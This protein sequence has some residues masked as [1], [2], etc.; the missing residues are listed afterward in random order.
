MAK[1][2]AENEL[3]AVGWFTILT[4]FEVL[5]AQRIDS[6]AADSSNSTDEQEYFAWNVRA[7]NYG[8]KTEEHVCNCSCL[9][10]VCTDQSTS[11]IGIDRQCSA[12]SPVHSRF[13]PLGMI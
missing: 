8:A 1:E 12:V 3:L 11:A 6:R 13:S 5:N 10:C 4:V 9:C 7:A 2:R